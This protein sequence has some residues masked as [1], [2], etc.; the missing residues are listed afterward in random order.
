M[1]LILAAFLLGFLGSMHCVGMCGGLVTTLAM[2]RKN[3]WWSGLM[4]YQL[5]RTLTYTFFGLIAGMIGMAINQIDWFADIQRAL[6]LFAGLLMIMFGLGL[7][8]WMPDPF[9]KVMAK[10]TQ[11]IGRAHV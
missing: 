4:S 2:S 9:V 1:E 7:A 3:I 8:G 10:F 11:Q 5:G 6:T